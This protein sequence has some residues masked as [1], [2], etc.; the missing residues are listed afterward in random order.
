MEFKFE[1]LKEKVE[2]IEEEYLKIA[3][4]D[5][6]LK[7]SYTKG[8]AVSTGKAGRPGLTFKKKNIELLKGIKLP[9]PEGSPTFKFFA[10]A[11]FEDTFY[12]ELGT[13]YK[14]DNMNA[15]EYEVLSPDTGFIKLSI[16]DPIHSVENSL[17]VRHISKNYMENTNYD[18]GFISPSLNKFL[19][20]VEK[21]VSYPDVVSIFDLILKGINENFNDA[22]YEELKLN[23]SLSMKSSWGLS[24]GDKGKASS[25]A[26]LKEKPKSS[27]FSQPSSQVQPIVQLSGYLALYKQND[28]YFYELANKKKTCQ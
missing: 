11:K 19:K 18:I 14:V 23:L 1:K 26:S 7:K 10:L 9:S 12:Y 8:S 16:E 3:I 5:K 17:K 27:S 28:K 2:G 6:S 24:L 25:N 13:G 4:E 21:N 22:L 20:S 15:N